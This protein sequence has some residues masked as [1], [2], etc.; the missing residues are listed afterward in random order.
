VLSGV[1]SV[2]TLVGV[3]IPLFNQN[4][5]SPTPQREQKDCIKNPI[6]VLSQNENL[7]LPKSL[8]YLSGCYIDG[9]YTYQLKITDLVETDISNQYLQGLDW[10]VGLSVSETKDAGRMHS[11]VIKIRSNGRSI[12][13]IRSKSK[14]QLDEKAHVWLDSLTICNKE[15]YK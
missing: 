2:V 4:N 15:K 11:T 9:C 14:L 3:L 8:S 10:H 5:S 1:S 12:D 6:Q 7:N 13:E